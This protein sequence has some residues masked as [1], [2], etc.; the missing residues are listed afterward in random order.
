GFSR[1][2]LEDCAPKL[3][4]EGKRLLGVVRRNAQSMAKLIDDLLTFSR[5]GRQDLRKSRVDMDALARVAFQNA[6]EGAPGQ[7]VEFKLTALPPASAD[8][9][10][11][12]EVFLNLFSNAVKYS[13]KN[14]R[15]RIEAGGRK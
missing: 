10:L 5:L 12:G 6:L 3:D 15:A 14:P 13:S 4:D 2:L 11:L 7:A 1:L 8:Q 9:V